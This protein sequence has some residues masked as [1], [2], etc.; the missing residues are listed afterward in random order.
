MAIS[1]KALGN[2]GNYF[3]IFKK[4]TKNYKPGTRRLTAVAGKSAL[5][6]FAEGMRHAAEAARRL[7]MRVQDQT[8][9]TNLYL[10]SDKLREVLNH[11]KAKKSDMVDAMQYALERMD[12]VRL[13]IKKKEN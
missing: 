12:Y 7:A 10:A 9:E 5:E 11:K 4:W 1:K 2:K 6:G 3:N 13:Y 8:E